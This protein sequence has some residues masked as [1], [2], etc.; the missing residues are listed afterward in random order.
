MFKIRIYI[1][2]SI[3]Q[4]LEALYFP[5]DNDIAKKIL[6]DA[7]IKFEHF[8]FYQKDFKND[9]WTVFYLQSIHLLPNS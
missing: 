7:I 3:S 9:R 4:E 2:V 5:C 6:T 1:F 8:V